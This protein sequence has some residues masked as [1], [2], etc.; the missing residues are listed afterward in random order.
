MSDQ[1]GNDST[2]T[3]A[4]ERLNLVALID[5]LPL[6]KPQITILVLCTLGGMAGTFAGG[7]ISYV[8]PV[9]NHGWHLNRTE[10]GTLFSAALF[11]MMFGCALIGIVGDRFGRKAAMIISLA[12][13]SLSVFTAVVNT[14]ADLFI[15]R[16][17]TGLGVGAVIPTLTTISSEFTPRRVRTTLVNVTQLGLPAGTALAGFVT[18]LMIG[19]WGWRSVFVVAGV[20]PLILMAA[21]LALMPESLHFLSRGKDSAQHI[22]RVLN[23]LDPSSNYSGSHDYYLPEIRM[24][25]VP[26]KHLFHPALIRNTLLL[27][28]AFFLNLLAIYLF[29]TWLPLLLV[30][31]GIGAARAASMSAIYAVAGALAVIPLGWLM[32]RFGSRQVLGVGFMLNALICVGFSMFG[33]PSAIILYPVIFAAG[34]LTIGGQTGLNTMTVAAYP[35]DVRTTGIGWALSVGRIG[36]IIG[37]ILGA[38]LAG[39]R[40]SLQSFLFIVGLVELVAMATTMLVKYADLPADAAVAAEPQAAAS[41]IGLA[42]IEK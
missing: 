10:M 23:R 13:I 2:G 12:L 6:T 19:G 4:Q 31:S 18:A 40:T 38:G 25:G 42:A 41:G 28:L 11:G 21:V 36:A 20:I 14:F 34:F 8:A 33:A 37:P 32:G 35:S 17:I 9:A 3:G 22:A 26:V 7:A 5:S 27:W 1:Q 16:F 24:E 30:G 29:S 39:S 15:C